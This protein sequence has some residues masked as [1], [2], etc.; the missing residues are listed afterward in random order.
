M[1]KW[2]EWPYKRRGRRGHDRVVVGFINTYAISAYH[3]LSCEFESH[4][5]EVYSIQHYVIKFV[6]DLRTVGGFLRIHLLPP[7]IKLI[8]TI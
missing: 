3:H 5:G 8:A 7:P 2:W 6:S 4:S 1:L